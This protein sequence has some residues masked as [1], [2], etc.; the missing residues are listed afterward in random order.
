MQKNKLR[1]HQCKASIYLFNHADSDK[2]SVYKTEAEHDHDDDSSRGISEN[3]KKCINE[4]YMDGIMKSKQIIRALQARNVKTPTA[5][6]IKNYLIQYKKNKF[7]A[8]M[9]SLGELEQWCKRIVRLLKIASISSHINLAK[10][11]C[12]CNWN[13]RFK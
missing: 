9:I 11:S 6:Q 3:I 13:N 7:G 5:I 2:V 4:L 12:S 8:Y 10:I 1:G